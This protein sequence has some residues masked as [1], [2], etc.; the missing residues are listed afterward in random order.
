MKISLMKS[1]SIKSKDNIDSLDFYA[2]IEPLLGFYEAYDELYKKYLNLIESLKFENGDLALDFG[3]GNGKFSLLLSSKF[4]VLGLDISPKMA[5]ICSLKG[6]KTLVCPIDKLD[7]EFDLITAVSDVLNYMTQNELFKFF[8]SAS[9][10]LKP[11]GYLIFDLNTQFGFDSVAS[12]SLYIKDKNNDLIIDSNYENKSLNTEF[13]Y[14]EEQD[15]LYKKS[16]FE[17]T[18][19]YHSYKFIKDNCPL[20]LVKTMKIELFSDS[21]ADKEIYIFQKQT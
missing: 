14:F 3:C 4:K 8:S 20:E 16:K 10:K 11:G 1:L 19:Y 2:K 21:L 15:N 13:I 7:M 9:N 6:I 5:E 18:Q 12:G 17:I